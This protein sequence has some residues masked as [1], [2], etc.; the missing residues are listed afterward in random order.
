MSNPESFVG[1]DV[2]KGWLDVAWLT[3]ETLRIDHA[4][5]AIAV[6]VERLRSQPPALV[7]MEATGGLETGVASALAAAGLAVAV[8][9]PR[10]VRDY[11]KACGRL[12]KTDRIDALILAAF[13]AAIR[14]QVRE[15]PD[16]HTRALG[17]LLA[18][19]RQLVEM[20]VQEKLRLQRASNVQ[21]ASLREHIVWLDERI[22][23]LDIDLTHALRSSP[24]WRDKDDLLK[25]IPGVGSLTRA[26][27]LALLPELGTLSRRQI[28]AL[29]GVAPF[30]RDSGQHQGGRVIWGG[31]AQV[32][33]TLYM[34]AVAP[35]RCNPVIRSFY[36]HLRS[37]GKPAKVALTACMR[38]LLVTMNAMLKHHSAWSNRLDTQ[39]SC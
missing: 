5:K 16:E 1:I 33:R 36:Q 37:Q 11:A 34:A 39:H 6:L 15:L 25:P 17:D 12:A 38:K 22:G 29:V 32:R 2:A 20:R 21:R 30:N 8:V 28:A 26:T 27:M 35:M 9:N 3:G 13:A 4:E 18:R 7:V 14:P 24:A 31:R 10:Q 19:R 23:R